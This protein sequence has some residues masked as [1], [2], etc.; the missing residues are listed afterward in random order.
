MLC[1]LGMSGSEKLVNRPCVIFRPARKHKW[2]MGKIIG[3]KRD[4]PRERKSRFIVD[5][6]VYHEVELVFSVRM[7][8]KIGAK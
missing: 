1:F 7:V 4:C 8:E 3:R 2:C 6:G 5:L